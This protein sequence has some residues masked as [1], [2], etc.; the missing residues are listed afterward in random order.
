MPA[1]RRRKRPRR[2]NAF[3][4][5]HFE[6]HAEA[7]SPGTGKNV[8]RPMVRNVIK[9]VRPD[10]IQCEVK[11]A[12]GVSAYPT[13]VGYAAGA[14]TRDPLRIW[15]D[16]TRARGVALY[17][18]VSGLS[19]REASHR[20][21]SWARVGPD[22]KRDGDAVSVFSP[23]VEALLLPQLK[24]LANVYGL[25]GAWMDGDCDA[26]EPDYADAV[27]HAFRKET[28][29]RRLPA[30]PGHKHWPEFVAFCHEAFLAYLR[31][32]VDEV[33]VAAPEFEI[34][35]SGAF[36]H[37]MPEPVTVDVDFLTAS[38]SPL[39]SVN[40]A[41]LMGRCLADQGKP[42][43][44]RLSSA[45]RRP[46]QVGASTKTAVQLKQEAAVVMAL[47]GALSVAFPQKPEG[48]VYEWQVGLMAEIAD[49]CRQR[50]PYCR[51]PKPVPQLALLY[52]GLPGNG[53]G[54]SLLGPGTAE[55]VAF[56]GILQVLLGL[57]YSVQVTMAH[58]LLGHVR[59]YP[60][61]VVPEGAQLDADLCEELLAYVLGGGNLLVLGPSAA[62]HFA[63]PLG[64]TFKN[65]AD[66]MGE[67]WLAFR[68]QLGAV[69]TVSAAV[70]L[71]GTAEA[72]GWLYDDN[73]AKGDGRPA[74][75]VIACG[76]GTMA[77]TYLNL[78]EPFARCATS[79][80][81]R[82][83]DALVRELFAKPV[84]EIPGDPP[85]DVV[86]TRLKGQLAV[87]VVNTGG[88]H[89]D[90]TVDTFDDLPALAPLEVHVRMK[91]RPERVLLQ[92]GNRHLAFHFREGAAEITLPRLEFHEIIVLEEADA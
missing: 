72:R 39:D 68:D 64:V 55:L 53:T 19:D 6:G 65:D 82:F 12:G 10:Y 26:L 35:S 36:S 27:E 9:K 43:D 87:H 63:N 52:A 14:F 33:H 90:P 74:A 60:L 51:R 32:Y 2:K 86:V 47:G 13:E 83:L 1:R 23:Y 49:F 48:A 80:A 46:G 61:I 84:V 31:R 24:E 69:R 71:K 30:G 88:P 7:G 70:R 56:E 50:Q 17:G 38:V 4:G 92:P 57:H 79:A 3:F 42:W 62:R 66:E 76:E 78:G 22:G 21:T 28:G 34:A 73:E 5:I 11:G 37:L 58:N 45:R 15:R 40:A 8:T 75:S 29:V 16:V 91:R 41:R 59:G 25:D 54:P 77:A 89:A 44:L 18:H 85:V 81:R 20:H 67:Q